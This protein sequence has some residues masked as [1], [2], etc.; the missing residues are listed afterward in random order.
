MDTGST[1]HALA[2]C[3]PAAVVARTRT[4]LILD[5]PE[6]FRP[7]WQRGRHDAPPPRAIDVAANLAAPWTSSMRS[8]AHS[9]KSRSAGVLD[10]HPQVPTYPHAVQ[11]SQPSLWIS[12]G[13]PHS[14]QGLPAC[15]GAAVPAFFCGA[16]STPISR[17]G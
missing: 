4:P 6:S 8:A 11:K 7:A 2:D 3:L 15:S 13:L 9:G 1:N 14:G 12:V 16:S 17:K 10:P 5:C